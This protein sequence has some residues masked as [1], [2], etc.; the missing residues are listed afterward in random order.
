MSSSKTIFSGFG[1]Q[2]VL[3]M[4]YGL[5]RGAM[6]AGYNVTFLPSY[7]AEM[8]G[9]TANCT[10]CV[11]QEE[12]ASPIASTPDYLVVMNI[13][14]LFVFQNRVARNGIIFINSSMVNV[15]PVRNDVRIVKVDCV[16]IAEEFG[17]AQ[18]ANIAM[19]GEF[20]RETKVVSKENFLEGLRELLA[21]KKKSVLE[22]NIRTFEAT[23]NK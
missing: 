3:M 19:L 23:Y 12:I 14:S 10:V 22:A 20:L 1:G 2:G 21:K 16:R 7:G 17:S 4:G 6:H 11:S 18:M 8:R 9:G 5:A 13:P 15:E